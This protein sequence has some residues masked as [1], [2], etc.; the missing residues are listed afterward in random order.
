MTSAFENYSNDVA[1]QNPTPLK[2][3]RF[4]FGDQVCASAG[5]CFPDTSNH[6]SG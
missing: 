1:Y 3:T 2:L 4:L 6:Q 5:R